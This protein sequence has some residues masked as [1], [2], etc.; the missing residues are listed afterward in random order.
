MGKCRERW[1]CHYGGEK[2]GGRWAS[3]W[4]MLYPPHCI[5]CSNEWAE[6][7][8]MGPMSNFFLP[9]CMGNLVYC[10]L[11]ER[12]RDRSSL[13]AD[14]NVSLSRKKNCKSFSLPLFSLLLFLSPGQRVLVIGEKE[15]PFPPSLLVRSLLAK[16]SLPPLPP[17][18][19]LLF[20]FFLGLLLLD[21]QAMGFAK[22]S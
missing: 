2:R 21:T 5:V 9:F 16:K 10:A 8:C 22:K 3:F 18:N 4:G 7:A 1:R 19:S 13:S 6:D 15:V 17:A 14:E 20:F 11:W 12:R